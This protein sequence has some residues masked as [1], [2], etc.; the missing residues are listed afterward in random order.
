MLD[1]IAF[2]DSDDIWH[3]EKIERQLEV[4]KKTRTFFSS[5]S[6]FNFSESEG[7]TFPDSNFDV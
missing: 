3:S 7:L 6:M 1:Y 4:M 2:I 5:T